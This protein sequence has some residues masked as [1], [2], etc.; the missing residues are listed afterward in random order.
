MPL[1]IDSHVHFY[2]SFR[3]DRFFAAFRA[4][5]ARNGAREAAVMLLCE[6]EGQD[7]FGEWSSGRGLPASMRVA[8]REERALLLEGDDGGLP[9]A[10]VAGRQIACAERV[11]ILALG[12]RERFRDGIP[13]SDAVAAAL[14]AGSFPVLAWGVGK[15]LLSRAR[16][17]DSLLRRWPAEELALG[18][19]SLR[20]TF[21]PTPGP[22]AEGATLGRRVL[23]GS[24]PLPRAFEETRAGQYGD[25]ADDVLPS[26]RPLLSK[27]LSVL[28]DDDLRPAGRRAGPLQFARRMLLK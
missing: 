14:D 26:D 5:A 20:P 21:W 24:D 1:F 22:M 13:A 28:R 11:E 2:P 25:L 3:P 27:I 4:A 8:R 19:T 16:V 6:R 12:T 18:D 17:V 7:V 23:R 10:V 9:V 15:W